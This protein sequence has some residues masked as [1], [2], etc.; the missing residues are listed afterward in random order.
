MALIEYDLL[1]NVRD[2]VKRAI[3]IAQ[4]FEPQDGYYLAYSGG[5]DSICVEKI[6]QL[7]GVK[8][9]KH[10]NVTTVDPPELVRF[11]INQHNTVI[12]EMPDGSEKIYRVDNGKLRRCEAIEGNVVYFQIPRLPMRKLIVERKMP[13]TRLM[14]YCCE[15]LKEVTGEGRVVVTGV[16][17]AESVNRKANQ[18]MVTFPNKK[19]AAIAEEQGANY[20]LTKRGGVVL[21]YDDAASRRTVEQCYRTHKTLVNPIIDFTEEDVWEFIKAYNLPY[22]SLYDKGFK[23]LGCVGCPLGGAASQRREFEMWPQYRK[24]YQSAFQKM[25]EARIAEG[26]TNHNGLW[27]DGAGIMRWWLGYDKKWHPDQMTIGELEDI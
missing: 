27:T 6:L 13:P 19:V 20:M 25:L 12:Y 22:C 16:R 3:E 23:R 7:A 5:K 2:K 24:L 21:N 15:E 4:C 9:D 18:G 10:Y 14:R 26:K 17:S 1:G 11:I 8:Y